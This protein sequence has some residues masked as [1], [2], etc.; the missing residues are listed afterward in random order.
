MLDECSPEWLVLPEARCRAMV[1]LESNI[2]GQ[3][4]MARMAAMV[5]STSG[6]AVW[7]GIA[8]ILL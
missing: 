2:V 1:L 5:F 8:S 6:R 3:A 7:G 4:S